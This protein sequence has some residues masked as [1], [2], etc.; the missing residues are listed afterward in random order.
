MPFIQHSLEREKKMS[1]ILNYRYKKLSP[2]H[3]PR[4]LHIWCST[5][6]SLINVY[7][8]T[9]QVRWQKTPRFDTFLSTNAAEICKKNI[10]FKYSGK[11][12]HFLRD[13]NYF[14]FSTESMLLLMPHECCLGSPQSMHSIGWFRAQM[15]LL[16]ILLHSS[17]S[18]DSVSFP[19][20]Q[21]ALMILAQMT[22]VFSGEKL[23]QHS[24]FPTWG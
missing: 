5:Q 11:C 4:Q 7:T 22:N 16:K 19:S 10:K 15:I 21:Q 1:Q 8:K 2:A 6:K 12:L 20:L 13:L 9:S 18:R 24:N 3:V 17:F 23:M 14:V